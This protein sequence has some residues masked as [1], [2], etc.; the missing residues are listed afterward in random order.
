[1]ITID[2]DDKSQS[3]VKN[4]ALLMKRM[5]PL[6]KVIYRISSNRKGGHIK[7]LGVSLLEEEEIN[8]RRIMGDDE[9]R[10][11]K[12]IERKNIGLPRQI[13]FNKKMNLKTGEIKSA[14]KWVML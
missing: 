12:D 6:S 2:L 1:M 7:A 9:K 5:F 3:F 11:S 8:L 13:L 4:K 14:G 10:I